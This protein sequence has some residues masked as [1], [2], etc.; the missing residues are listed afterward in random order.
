MSRSDASMWRHCK[1][2]SVD[3]N[4]RAIK[5]TSENRRTDVSQCSKFII[6]YE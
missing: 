2:M 6:F 3:F 5:I 4:L 1:K